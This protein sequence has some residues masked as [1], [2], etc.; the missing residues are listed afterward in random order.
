MKYKHKSSVVD[1]VQWNKPGDHP[2][3]KCFC[4]LGCGEVK[5]HGKYGDCIECGA[6]VQYCIVDP[7]T[8]KH[9]RP[10]A[11]D[12]ILTRSDGRLEVMPEAEFL[13]KYEKV[14]YDCLEC[15]G[16]GAFMT[17]LGVEECKTCNGT[18]KVEE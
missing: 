4:T 16:D 6:S 3:E 13:S 17:Y 5:T 12:Y 1:A 14:T 15:D 11:G 7:N 18:G 2:S 8:D 10:F 9:M